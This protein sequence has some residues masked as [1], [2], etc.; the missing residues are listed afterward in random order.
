M[1]KLRLITSIH[2]RPPTWGLPPS[3]HYSVGV[4][5]LCGK[6]EKCYF[7]IWTEDEG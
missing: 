7:N 2:W 6:E 3:L 1:V 5:V 4:R